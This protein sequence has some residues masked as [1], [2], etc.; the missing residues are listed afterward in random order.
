MSTDPFNCDGCH[1]GAFA[2]FD[3]FCDVLGVQT[4]ELPHAFAAYLG[5]KTDWNGEYG[6]VRD[7]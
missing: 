1:N 4:H 3:H 5:H 6:E 2:G 7:V